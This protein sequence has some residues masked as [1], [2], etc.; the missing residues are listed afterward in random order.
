[1]MNVTEGAIRMQRAGRAMVIIALAAFV[2]SAVL[3]G[4]YAFLP[5]SFHIAEMFGVLLPAV[6]TV[7]W[8][9]AMAIAAGSVLWI[10]GWILEGFAKSH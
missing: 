4:I 5:S 8:M 10:A 6:F 3:S 7:L 1:M 9:S 2:L